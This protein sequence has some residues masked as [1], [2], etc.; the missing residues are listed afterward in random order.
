MDAYRLHPYAPS[1]GTSLY[2]HT[3]GRQAKPVFASLV[4][5]MKQLRVVRIG[6]DD[7]K[8]NRGNGCNRCNSSNFASEGAS[9]FLDSCLGAN[10]EQW[11]GST[12]IPV[13]ADRKN[14]LM[15]ASLAEVCTG[16]ASV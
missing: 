15:V 12:P 10:V 6:R 16:Y 3:C 8:N 5:T 13:K 1:A 2:L 9:D 11:E 4:S 14:G 7:Q